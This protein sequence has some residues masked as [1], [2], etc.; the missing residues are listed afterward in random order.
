M[1]REGESGKGC[2]CC[3]CR[4]LLLLR[5][6][7]LVHLMHNNSCAAFFGCCWIKLTS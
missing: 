3:C 4:F 6:G 1:E 5:L 2:C 7:H